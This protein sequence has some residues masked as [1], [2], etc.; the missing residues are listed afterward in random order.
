MNKNK[1]WL[2][3]FEDPRFGGVLLKEVISA[4]DKTD[5]RDLFFE[6]NEHIDNVKRITWVPSQCQK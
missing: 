1:N 5:A 3:E 6:Q 2:V 4:K